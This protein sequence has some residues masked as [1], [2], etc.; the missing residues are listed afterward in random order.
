MMD[1]TW[2]IIAATF[3]I[4]LFLGYI[5]F[6]DYRK[7][8]ALVKQVSEKE[9]LVETIKRKGQRLTFYLFAFATVLFAA[10]AF[11][12]PE[13]LQSLAYIGVFII[14]AGTEWVNVLTV[15][16]MSVFERTLV[17]SIFEIRIKSIRTLSAS[18]KRN[19]TV[20][21]LDGTSAL[22]PGDVGEKLQSLQKARKAK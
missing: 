21:M 13:P 9:K 8:T 14:L 11:F 16:T 15:E 4:T 5:R 3:A 12:T 10:L 17:Y 20:A 6:N 18:G 2:Y 19:I 7:H 22:V 1:Y